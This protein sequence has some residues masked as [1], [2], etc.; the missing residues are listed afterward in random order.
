MSLSIETERLIIRR[1]EQRDMDD[2][3]EYLSD[4]EI[5]RYEYWYPYTADDLAEESSQPD[6]VPGTEGHWLELAR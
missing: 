3:L 5:A 1:F 2:Q 6:S 4:P